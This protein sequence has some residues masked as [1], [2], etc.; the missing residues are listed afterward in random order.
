MTLGARVGAYKKGGK[1]GL[2]QILGMI[3]S[4]SLISLRET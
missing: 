1:R 2:L 3:L 4:H